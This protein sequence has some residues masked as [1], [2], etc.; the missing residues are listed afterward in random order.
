MCSDVRSSVS[1]DFSILFQ[2][3]RRHCKLSEM[4]SLLSTHHRIQEIDGMGVGEGWNDG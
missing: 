1:C 3:H 2:R 4:R